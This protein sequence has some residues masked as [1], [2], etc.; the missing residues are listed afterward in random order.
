MPDAEDADY[1]AV[2]IETDAVVARAEAEL[3]R[4]DPAKLFDVTE[5]GVGEA[6]DG[7]F[8]TVG[9]ASIE[10]GH[11]QQRGPGPLDLPHGS[12]SLYSQALHGLIMWNAFAA[13]FLEP[14]A[15]FGCGLFFL[16]ALRLVI[17][18]R[19]VE[20]SGHGVDQGFE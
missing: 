11:I 17:K 15:G 3:G 19:I 13:V 5:G 12:P 6:L 18:G 1:A 7:A 9:D 20:S 2:L 4:V 10:P 16:F 8:D 14:V